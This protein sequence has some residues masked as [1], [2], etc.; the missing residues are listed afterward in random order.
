MG[1]GHLHGFAAERSA[2]AVEIVFPLIVRRRG[3]VVALSVF[4]CVADYFQLAHASG[5]IDY[6]AAAFK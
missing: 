5:I 4:E 6:G 1:E 2:G 3:P